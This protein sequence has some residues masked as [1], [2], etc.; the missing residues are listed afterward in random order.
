[1]KNDYEDWDNEASVPNGKP[2]SNG[3]SPPVHLAVL[4]LIFAA[5]EC[6]LLGKLLSGHG[7]VK[8]LSAAMA[9]GALGMVRAF[10]LLNRKFEENPWGEGVLSIFNYG[11]FARLRGLK[12]SFVRLCVALGCL[13]LALTLL[14]IYVGRTRGLVRTE[15]TVCNMNYHFMYQVKFEANGGTQY[16]RFPS[17]VFSPHDQASIPVA[18]DLDNPRTA[19][20]VGKAALYGGP[21]EAGLL[22]LL[23]LLLSGYPAWLIR[24]CLLGRRQEESHKIL[25]EDETDE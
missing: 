11:I 23:F 4:L 13:L 22:G 19:Y 16:A 5:F 9:S 8:K 7:D 20:P 14:L 2:A 15:A 3:K 12:R 18:Y 6:L 10:Q 17:V 25:W 21:M 1:M 24:V